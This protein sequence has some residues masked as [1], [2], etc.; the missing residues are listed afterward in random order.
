MVGRG[1]APWPYDP[2]TGKKTNYVGEYAISTRELH[3]DMVGVPPWTFDPRTGVK[4]ET[5][6]GYNRRYVSQ[7][8]MQGVKR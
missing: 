3:L 6:T 8:G 4:T 1:V 5:S 2:R 7:Y